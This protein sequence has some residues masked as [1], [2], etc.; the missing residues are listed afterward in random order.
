MSHGLDET[1]IVEGVFKAGRAVGSRMQIAKKLGVDL[2]H[3]DGCTHE[4]AGNRGLLGCGKWNAGLQ[5]EVPG[6][7]SRLVR[8]SHPLDPLTSRLKSA[9]SGATPPLMSAVNTAPEC[10]FPR[11]PT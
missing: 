7:D 1:G 9:S 2:S 5:L 8:L 10:V 11:T 3:V 6:L 4:A